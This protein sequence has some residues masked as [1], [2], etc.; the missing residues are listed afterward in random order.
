VC[1]SFFTRRSL[2]SSLAMLVFTAF[3]ILS[4]FTANADDRKLTTLPLKNQLP[5]QVLPVIRPLLSTGSTATEFN[6]QLILNVTDEEL[7]KIRQL[8]GAIDQRPKQLLL[9]VRTPGS[10][11]SNSRNVDIDGSIG[12]DNERLG[13]GERT[14]G[15]SVPRKDEQLRISLDDRNSSTSSS[16]VQ[17]VRAAE[18]MPAQISIGVT[19]P[20][21]RSYTTINGT[22][23]VNQEYYPV[24]QSINVVARIIDNN[25]VILDI[26]QQNNQLGNQ[27]N[28]QII[29]RK[30]IPV[31]R[32][33]YSREIH[34]APNIQTQS[35]ST[36][37]SGRIG[38]W[39]SLGGIDQNSTTDSGSF[40]R[41]GSNTSSE[42]RSVLIKVEVLSD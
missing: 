22:R 5:S 10:S 12:N 19:T 33:N 30:N 14:P 41:S 9:T 23:V 24:N 29:Q 35:L 39:I 37:V 18:G 25:R 20:I 2:V 16:G 38:E 34:N 36:Q 6:N 32:N 21:T 4:T 17:Q 40:N 27:Q 26:D 1:I 15:N 28:H 13:T 11:T 3:T 7:A 8:L 31:H 42:S